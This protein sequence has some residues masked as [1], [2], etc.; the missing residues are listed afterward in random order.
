MIPTKEQRTY[1]RE[2]KVSSKIGVRKN[3]QKRNKRRKEG[4]EKEIKEA[5]LK[6]KKKKILWTFTLGSLG[7]NSF[8]SLV[9]RMTVSGP[10]MLLS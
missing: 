7:S 2:S 5:I 8:E 1:N 10:V 6:P 9:G 4:K 3:I